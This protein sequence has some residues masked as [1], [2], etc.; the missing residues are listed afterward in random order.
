MRVPLICKKVVDF[1]I[2]HLKEN[3]DTWFTIL[4]AII[5][6]VAPKGYQ[7]LVGGIFFIWLGFVYFRE[8]KYP[9]PLVENI[10]YYTSRL[11]ILM[12]IFTLLVYFLLPEKIFW[13]LLIFPILLFLSFIYL[14]IKGPKGKYKGFLFI[15]FS[16]PFI[17][18]IL[19]FISAVGK[20]FQ[21][22]GIYSLFF[23]D[24]SIT[25]LAM[26]VVFLMFKGIS[27]A[28][29]KFFPKNKLARFLHSM[30]GS[31]VFIIILGILL[32]VNF[33]EGGLSMQ[34]IRTS[35]NLWTD[36]FRGIIIV[37]GVIY[38]YYKANN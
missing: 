14:A 11:L 6:F 38:G 10:P 37:L 29:T 2:N 31:L 34:N 17:S 35:L 27:G 15:V 3:W 32:F 30:K 22:K 33:T 25:L 28:L 19:A 7:L 26:I 5:F 4:L 8:E 20:L 36:Y 1:S 12:G 16:I 18:S 24:L 9:S 21:E 13:F 23:Y